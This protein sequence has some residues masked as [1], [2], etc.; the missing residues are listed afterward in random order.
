M[1]SLYADIQSIV[2]QTVAPQLDIPVVLYFGYL[3]K[4]G[5][6]SRVIVSMSKEDVKKWV[7]LT[8]GVV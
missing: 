1:Q 8:W 2:I 4:L 6:D 7:Q 5:L 3:K